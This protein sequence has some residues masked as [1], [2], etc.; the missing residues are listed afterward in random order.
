MSTREEVY[1]A[2]D[3]ERTYQ[4]RMWNPDTTPSEGKHTASEYILYMEHYLEEARKIA[5][6]TA[7]GNPRVLDFV[8]KVAGLAVA[9]ME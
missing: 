9:C 4:D 1:I 8:R 6:T 5:S 2:I 3:S 7:E